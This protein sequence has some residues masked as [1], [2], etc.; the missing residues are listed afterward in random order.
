MLFGTR[1]ECL[2]LRSEDG[3]GDGDPS[4]LLLFRPKTRQRHCTAGMDGI[5]ATGLPAR[6]RR[7]SGL[8]P[9][10]TWARGEPEEGE[11]R[12]PLL[13]PPRGAAVRKKG[14]RGDPGTCWF[15]DPWPRDDVTNG[16]YCPLESGEDSTN[17]IF[18]LLLFSL[19]DERKLGSRVFVSPA[20]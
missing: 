17:D 18:S 5:R 19:L 9:S 13:W 20:L 12:I 10:G 3:E 11:H 14:E 1:G 7:S 2:L 16:E 4:S 6:R 15:A 8:P